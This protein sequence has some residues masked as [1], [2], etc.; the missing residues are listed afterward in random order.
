[1]AFSVVIG[2]VV[3]VVAY[4]K[5]PGQVSAT[6]REWQLTNI[7]GG[8]SISS[9]DIAPYFD[10]FFLSNLVPMLGDGAD[11]YG[12]QVYYLTPTPPLPRPEP[13]VDTVPGTGGV[14]ILP[15]QT[16]GLISLYSNDL[17]RSGQGRVYVPF[18]APGDAND[19]GTPTAGYMTKLNALKNALTTNQT[20]PS[21]GAV[22]T[23]SPVLYVPGGPPPKLIT[24]GIARDA[25]ATQ[26]R[27]GAYG[28]V[29]ANPF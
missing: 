17:G 15:T 14:G 12:C 4:C 9:T 18:P 10:D 20:V 5:V 28:R 19:D 21:G 27:R 24:Y 11:Y 8:T 1:M 16:S 7:T 3:K 25:W 13:I 6:A 22:G 23:F 2:G 29:N 26:R